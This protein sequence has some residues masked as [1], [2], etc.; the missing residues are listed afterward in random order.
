M[1]ALIL[2]PK[3]KLENNKTD[4]LRY[5]KSL[6]ANRIDLILRSMDLAFN[7]GQ[8]DGAAEAKKEVMKVITK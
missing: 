4:L 5:I 1:S 3:E 2:T 7:L 6:D 8:L